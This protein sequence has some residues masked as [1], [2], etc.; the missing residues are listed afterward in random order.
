VSAEMITNFSG[1]EQR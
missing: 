1:D